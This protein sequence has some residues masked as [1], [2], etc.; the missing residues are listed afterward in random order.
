MPERYA[1]AILA[2]TLAKRWWDT[3]HAFHIADL[4]MTITPYNFHHMTRL[5]FTRDLISL[6]DKLGI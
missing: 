5:Q 6:E 4:E 2:Q 1:N 3:T